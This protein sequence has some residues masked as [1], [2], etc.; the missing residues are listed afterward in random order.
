MDTHTTADVTEEPEMRGGYFNSINM[1]MHSLNSR[2]M[3]NTSSDDPKSLS[4]KKVVLR[5]PM[6]AATSSGK[7][8]RYPVQITQGSVPESTF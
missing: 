1:G 2:S 3:V 8:M 7:K 5:K 6:T 4:T